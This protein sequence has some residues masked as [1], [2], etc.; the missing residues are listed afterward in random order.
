MSN[1]QLQQHVNEDL[2]EYAEAI[3]PYM[4]DLANNATFVERPGQIAGQAR[5]VRGWHAIGRNVRA[6]L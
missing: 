5:I 2:E 1:A 3:K 6:L 4:R